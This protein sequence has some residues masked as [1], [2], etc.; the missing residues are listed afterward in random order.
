VKNRHT[1]ARPSQHKTALEQNRDW[2]LNGQR[3]LK[4]NNQKT[5]NKNNLRSYGYGLTRNLE[6]FQ[7][8]DRPK[9]APN[10]ARL[11][12]PSYWASRGGA[13]SSRPSFFQPSRASKPAR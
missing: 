1:C 5:H 2:W 7:M 11:G 6:N 4:N 8:G 10:R 9:H 12:V 3:Q 13:L